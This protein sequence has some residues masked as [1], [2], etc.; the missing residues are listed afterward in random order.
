M[1]FD[2]SKYFNAETIEKIFRIGIILVIGLIIIYTIAHIV[3]KLLP[4]KFPL[5][6]KPLQE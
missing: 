6:P 2:W 3:K 5:K 4:Q 1:N